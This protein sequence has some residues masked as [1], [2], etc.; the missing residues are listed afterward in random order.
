MKST[1][2]C[3]TSRPHG[4]RSRVMARFG[5]S[6][7]VW[8]ILASITGLLARAQAGASRGVA[9]RTDA[10]TINLH[11]ADEQSTVATALF[12]YVDN[13]RVLGAFIALPRDRVIRGFRIYLPA[14]VSAD[15]PETAADAPRLLA[16]HATGLVHP[17]I[18]GDSVFLFISVDEQPMPRGD[19]DRWWFV[20]SA[21]TSDVFAKLEAVLAAGGRNATYPIQE[22][23]MSLGLSH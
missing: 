6:I 17:H 23:V 13:R 20:G 11:M 8:A 2:D 9:V 19:W 4:H 16:R 7:L 18:R 1:N 10:G 12:E 15:L 5:A 22:I 14:F 21:G 3:P